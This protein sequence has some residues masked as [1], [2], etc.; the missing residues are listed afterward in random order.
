MSAH[1]AGPKQAA[2]RICS[3]ADWHR[4]TSQLAGLLKVPLEHSCSAGHAKHRAA[5]GTTAYKLCDRAEARAAL[6]L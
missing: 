5:V 1:V 2:V 6:Q 3:L 4:A